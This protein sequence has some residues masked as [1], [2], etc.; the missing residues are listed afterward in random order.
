MPRQCSQDVGYVDDPGCCT[1]V[2]VYRLKCTV[3]CMNI[4][5]LETSSGK[6][7][8]AI[9]TLCIVGL[10]PAPGATFARFVAR[11][12]GAG[13]KADSRQDSQSKLVL[14]A[15]WTQCV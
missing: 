2:G 11:V 9:P 12:A 5:R 4:A 1:S 13:N 7:A 3:C 6:P 10:G 15:L 8:V 14:I